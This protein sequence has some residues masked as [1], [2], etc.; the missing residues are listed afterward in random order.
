M[1]AGYL[2]AGGRGGGITLQLHAQSEKE[3]RMCEKVHDLRL[4]T[5]AAQYQSAFSES[6]SRLPAFVESQLIFANSWTFS[7]CSPS[8]LCN[9]EYYLFTGF[10]A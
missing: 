1:A 9:V 6:H 7:A 10:F 4:R 2:E 8:P 5:A 3:G